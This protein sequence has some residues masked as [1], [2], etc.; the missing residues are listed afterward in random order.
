MIVD[1]NVLLH[2]FNPDDTSSELVSAGFGNVAT[3]FDLKIN[4]VIF[5]EISPAFPD[6]QAVAEIL[7]SMKINLTG[8]TEEDAFRAGQA[9]R[10][11]R[12]NGGPRTT[13][14]PDFLIGAQASVRGWPILTRDTKHFSTYFPE[15]ELIDPLKAQND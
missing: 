10:E 9:F 6:A 4:H 7:T 5:A 14:L 3:K 1:S 2:L 12:R 11:Y 13:V 15:V 8:L